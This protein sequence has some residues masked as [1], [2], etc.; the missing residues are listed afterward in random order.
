MRKQKLL[1]LALVIELALAAAVV[2]GFWIYK[3]MAGP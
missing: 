2:I 3:A 1:S